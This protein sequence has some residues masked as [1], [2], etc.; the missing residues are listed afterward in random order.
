MVVPFW[1][2]L[3]SR[4]F[5]FDDIVEGESKGGTRARVARGH[6]PPNYVLRPLH[7]MSSVSSASIGSALPQILYKI[8]SNVFLA[9]K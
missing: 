2:E 4:K 3:T 9:G 1:V 5:E 6:L 7:D 8:P